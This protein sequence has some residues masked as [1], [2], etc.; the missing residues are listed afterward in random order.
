MAKRVR[1]IFD[2]NFK[3]KVVLETLKEQKTLSQLSSEF[4]VHPNQITEW[5]K[6]VLASLPNVFGIPKPSISEEVQEEITAPLFQQIGQLKVENEFLKK[7]LRKY[8]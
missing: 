3:I 4:S 2:D 7:K 1:R 5:K 6:Q 8:S